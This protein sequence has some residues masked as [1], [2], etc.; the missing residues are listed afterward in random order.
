MLFTNEQNPTAVIAA[1]VVLFNKVLT[2]TLVL[3]AT[4]PPPNPTLTL[5]TKISQLATSNFAEG[6]DVLIPTFP[7]E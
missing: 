7:P 6:D 3:L 1:P 4:L 5:L 2:P